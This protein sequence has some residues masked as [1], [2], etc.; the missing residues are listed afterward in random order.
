MCVN[1]CS[2]LRM[3]ILLGLMLVALCASAQERSPTLSELAVAAWFPGMSG[4]VVP[5]TDAQRQ[6]LEVGFLAQHGRFHEA[7]NALGTLDRSS[8]P[9]TRA[10]AS[11][12]RSHLYYE[13]NAYIRSTLPRDPTWV[14]LAGGKPDSTPPGELPA[15]ARNDV[16]HARTL[17]KLGI[18]NCLMNDIPFDRT[19]AEN[20]PMRPF[21]LP[22]E[23]HMCE[24]W[25]QTIG[26]QYA[27]ILK[28]G[29][30][31]LLE[32]MFAAEHYAALGRPASAIQKFEDAIKTARDHRWD[33][34][35]AY[36]K[37]RCTDVTIDPTSVFDTFG[38]DTNSE[39]LVRGGIMTG[40]G[41]ARSFATQPASWP[42]KDYDEVARMLGS[43]AYHV[44]FR[45][46]ILA[47][48]IGDF[49]SA[50]AD[51]IQ[52]EH[53][54]QIANDTRAQ[55]LAMGY[56]A[57]LTGET[58]A[59]ASAVRLLIGEQD[60]GGLATL[61]ES[62]GSWA[63]RL[64]KLG[65]DYLSGLNRLQIAVTALADAGFVDQTALFQE[66][67]AWI[68]DQLS[69]PWAAL[70][71]RQELLRIREAEKAK[72]DALP[73]DAL[74]F[75]SLSPGASAREAIQNVKTMMATTY[76][77]L[78]SVEN[79]ATFLDIASKVKVFRK[80]SADREMQAIADKSA[81]LFRVSSA[82]QTMNCSDFVRYFDGQRSELYAKLGADLFSEDILA[83]DCDPSRH[84]RVVSALRA[85]APVEDLQT[86]IASRSHLQGLGI[87]TSVDQAIYTAVANIYLA[88][89]SAVQLSDV[90][91]LVQWTKQFQH[92]IADHPFLLQ[93]AVMPTAYNARAEQLRGNPEKAIALIREIRNDQDVWSS[94]AGQNQQFVLATLLEAEVS[95]H[96]AMGSLYTVQEIRH[97]WDLL[98]F[99][100]TGL[101]VSDPSS[102][103]R[104]ELEL[105]AADPRKTLSDE[106]RS[107]LVRFLSEPITAYAAKTRA[108]VR[109]DLETA[110]A[111]LPENTSLIAIFLGVKP[112]VWRFV[113]GRSPVVT[114]LDIST[115]EFLQ[116]IRSFDDAL[117]Y[118]DPG[119]SNFAA[120]I[121]KIL[122]EPLGTIGSNENFIISGTG[123]LAFELLPDEN[124]RPYF[125]NHLVVYT[126]E[127]AMRLTS[128]SSEVHSWNEQML[129][130]GA[131]DGNAPAA[132][133]EA[134][135]VAGLFN[136]T[137]LTG[138]RATT[139][140]VLRRLSSA[141][142][143]HIA[144]HSFVDPRNPLASGVVLTDG[145]LPGFK[146]FR[147]APSGD[148]VALSA[149]DSAVTSA[150]TNAAASSLADLAR[151]GGARWILASR[152]KVPDADT[153]KLM[154]DFYWEIVQGR[155]F[156]V[157][158][159]VAEI[160]VSESGRRLP[161]YF[162][163]FAL[164]SRDLQVAIDGFSP[165]LPLSTH[166]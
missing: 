152:W 40:S 87:S 130:V 20:E 58:P 150:A 67:I 97:I 47:R 65:R 111:L 44:L 15:E 153:A 57:I 19:T 7:E 17:L 29:E 123:T 33:S 118:A 94:L 18:E 31:L 145:V 151:I 124:G 100:M 146:L 78:A 96:D 51:Y 28:P 49:Q 10:G 138:N 103:E 81:A 127:L 63:I 142:F 131:S 120:Q 64:A 71:A 5:T 160:D 119:A 46:A 162:G 91:T 157:A 27:N 93:N 16:G 110:I 39:L 126:D 114:R 102:A 70:A 30:T 125:L 9:V 83:A 66:L 6:L 76:R 43:S 23:S 149:C 56:R 4:T 79:D 77:Q 113:R 60:W 36:L 41:Q 163:A 54:A 115:R 128:G 158:H 35:A 112:I 2:H 159:R 108:P 155:S 53:D 99:Q 148:L 59:Y 107:R 85:L 69:R 25:I 139:D 141:R 133:T 61:V 42:I 90:E 89:N 117:R 143:V 101:T 74:D 82:Y 72:L 3:T 165:R 144:S 98:R 122:V 50:S 140:E 12:F 106:Q 121:R 154:H 129:A 95:L 11:L 21:Q 34:A 73:T 1:E 62:T 37:M 136:T 116:L 132:H 24:M 92:V 164:T 13:R 166:Q 52:I 14:L 8:D 134:D 75:G 86:A 26:R 105:A 38:Y 156:A 161:Y 48:V 135:E 22:M 109:Q 68:T 80:N 55:A 104:L 147:H 32:S 45:K 137:A 88:L 84:A